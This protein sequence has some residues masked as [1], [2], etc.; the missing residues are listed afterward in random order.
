M[1][2]ADRSVVGDVHLDL[3][4]PRHGTDTLA[5]AA[6]ARKSIDS[7]D[8]ARD[9]KK[10]NSIRNAITAHGFDLLCWRCLIYLTAD[11]SAGSCPRSERAS[12]RRQGRDPWQNWQTGMVQKGPRYGSAYVCVARNAIH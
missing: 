3:L 6:R 4:M 11:S 2:E 1:F 7:G 9:N 12:C 10:H 8:Q 5:T